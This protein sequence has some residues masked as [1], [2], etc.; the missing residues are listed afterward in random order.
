M[1]DCLFCKI[2][3]GE[4]P[5]QKVYE[6]QRVLAFKDINP[7]APV[8]ILIIPKEHYKDILSIP[9]EDDILSEIKEAIEKVAEI[10]GVKESGFRV[11]TNCGENAG[12]SVAHLHFHLF[13]GKVLAWPAL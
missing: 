9:R 4:I 3:G 5:S 1:E 7:Q 12:Q 11:V 13:G 8:H 6:T 10:C 2:V